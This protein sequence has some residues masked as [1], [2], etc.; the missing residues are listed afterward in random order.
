[1]IQILIAKTG[2]NFMVQNQFSHTEH[3]KDVEA[4]KK[5]LC[6]FVGVSQVPFPLTKIEIMENINKRQSFYTKNEDYTD[7]LVEIYNG[8]KEK[9]IRSLRNETEKD[10]LNSLPPI[11]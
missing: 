7:T 8:P 6:Y 11:N 2:D 5:G 3:L 9:G 10:N 1:M 4:Q